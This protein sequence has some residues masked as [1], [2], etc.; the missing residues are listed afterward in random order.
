MIVVWNND[1]DLWHRAKPSMRC[2]LDRTAA[3]VD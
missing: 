2:C 3:L 1:R